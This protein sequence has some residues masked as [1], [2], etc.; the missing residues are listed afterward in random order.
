MRKTDPNLAILARAVTR[1]GPLVDKMV[2]LGGCAT[3]LLVTDPA[4]PEVRPT[5]DVDVITEVGSL[6]D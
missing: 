5:Q 1:L 2:F 4:A 3:A 6:A